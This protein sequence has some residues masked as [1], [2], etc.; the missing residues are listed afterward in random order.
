AAILARPGVLRRPAVIAGGLVVFLVPLVWIVAEFHPRVG[1]SGAFGFLPGV[2]KPATAPEAAAA[3]GLRWALFGGAALALLLALA[4][5]IPRVPAWA[6]VLVLALDLTLGWHGYVPVT[7][8]S[9]S[10]LP[11]TKSIEVLR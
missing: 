1:L 4:L 6:L 8:T 7:T 5:R 11:T 2:A 9:Q 10:Q 3:A